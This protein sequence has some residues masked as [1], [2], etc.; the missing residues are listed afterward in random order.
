MWLGL[1]SFILLC[2]ALAIGS[3]VVGFILQIKDWNS[4]DFSSNPINRCTTTVQKVFYLMT[5]GFIPL[6][7]TAG[8]SILLLDF[9]IGSGM[10]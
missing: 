10:V 5:R 6:V 2:V 3:I 1:S 7:F 9:T 4:G 8:L